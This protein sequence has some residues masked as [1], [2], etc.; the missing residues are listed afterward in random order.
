VGLA[1]RFVALEAELFAES[2]VKFAGRE[3]GFDGESELAGV[4]MELRGSFQRRF[5]LGTLDFW[6]VV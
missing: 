4:V 3:L 2:G 1:H 5:S 6:R